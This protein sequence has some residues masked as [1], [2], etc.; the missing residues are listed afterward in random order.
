MQRRTQAPPMAPSALPGHQ[1]NLPSA[2]EGECG[3][4]RRLIA[5]RRRRHAM[6]DIGPSYVSTP[7]S[8]EIPVGVVICISASMSPTTTHGSPGHGYLRLCAVVLFQEMDML[9]RSRTNVCTVSL[10]DGSGPATL[11]HHEYGGAVRWVGR[12]QFDDKRS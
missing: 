2:I 3:Q 5:A 7:P 10:S 6:K 11:P 1:K 12:S 8:H 4:R 9:P